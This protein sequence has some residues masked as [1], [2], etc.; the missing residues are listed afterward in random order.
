M[1]TSTST[2]P[3]HATFH[4]FP[5]LPWELRTRIWELAVSPRTVPFWM[6]ARALPPSTSPLHIRR[7]LTPYCDEHP[8]SPTFTWALYTSS[9]IPAP[10]HACQEA[11]SHLTDPVCG[12]NGYGYYEKLSSSDLEDMQQ[13][14]VSEDKIHFPYI[15]V[16][17]EVDMIDISLAPF[18]LSGRSA[19]ASKCRRVTFTPGA[20]SISFDPVTPGMLH[21]FP[22]LRELE[23]E[24]PEGSSIAEWAKRLQWNLVGDLY[25]GAKYIVFTVPRG[26]RMTLAEIIETFPECLPPGY[27][28]GN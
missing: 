21:S 3:S 11:R 25:C 15:W 28:P 8:E 27:V 13:S 9:P 17:F 19:Y 22:N 1:T 10:L 6:K 20:P 18:G 7:Y 5:Y 24:L 4:H 2:S 14:W 23:M 16:N 12:V 26:K